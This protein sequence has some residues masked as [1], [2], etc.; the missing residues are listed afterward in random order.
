MASVVLVK[1]WAGG[2]TLPMVLLRGCTETAM[3]RVPHHPTCLDR[4]LP[5]TPAVLYAHRKGIPLL[6]NLGSVGW[7]VSHNRSGNKYV[8]MTVNHK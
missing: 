2:I 4:P 1:A 6:P 3:P 7:A 5:F 8:A